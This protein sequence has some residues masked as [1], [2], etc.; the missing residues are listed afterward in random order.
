MKV[1]IDLTIFFGSSLS[2]SVETAHGFMWLAISNLSSFIIVIGQK[3]HS[4]NSF[5]R[6]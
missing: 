5:S 6:Y 1:S 2:V 3:G 4:S